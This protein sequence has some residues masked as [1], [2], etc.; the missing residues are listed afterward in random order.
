MFKPICLSIVNIG[1]SQVI[2]SLK[3]SILVSGL[4][5]QDKDL[6]RE[7]TLAASNVFFSNFAVPEL[8]RDLAGHFRGQTQDH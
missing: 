2:S 1:W 3:N 6:R 5:Y 7:F 4:V 8:S